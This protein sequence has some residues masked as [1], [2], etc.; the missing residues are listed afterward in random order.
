MENS[1]INEID[2]ID[3]LG[4]NIAVTNMEKTVS[5][6]RDNLDKWRGKYICVA[7][8]HTTVMAHENEDYRKIQNES[9]I[10]L[11]DGGPLSSYSRR[12]GR[13]EAKRVTGPDLMKELLLRSNEY[14]WR[15]FFYGSTQQTLDMLKEKI[16]KDYPGATVAGMISPPYREL[17]YEEDLKYIDEINGSKPDFIW[18]GLG[19]PKQEIWMA[20]H[21]DRINGLMIGVGAAFDYESGNLKRAPKWM[22]KCNLEWFYRF[23]QE[24]RRLF[25]RYFVTNMKFL[26]LTRR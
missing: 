19:A 2:Y 26:W 7:N 11:P 8:V 18:I 17:S 25:K 10:A 22:Q 12:K 4:V 3:I 1:S 14:G 20:S 23:I 5:S 13:K 16:E 6:I 21:A 15:H 9:V 24:P